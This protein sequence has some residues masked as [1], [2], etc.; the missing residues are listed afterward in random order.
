M[1]TSAIMYAVR[2]KEREREREIAY[3]CCDSNFEIHEVTLNA[4]A[5]TQLFSSVSEISIARIG[6][7][8]IMCMCV[9]QEYHALS[10][11]G[12]LESE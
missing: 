3:N 6:I 1:I 8:R 11:D 2:E 12:C 9:R 10:A 7:E 5:R 4:N